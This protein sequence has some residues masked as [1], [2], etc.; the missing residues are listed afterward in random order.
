MRGC[1]GSCARSTMGDA[2]GAAC[3]GNGGLTDLNPE[4][5]QLAVNPRRTPERVGKAHLADQFACFPV[6]GLSPR[7]R[8]PA[9]VE[10]KALAVPL[11]HGCRLHQYHGP[12]ATRPDPVEPDPQHPI[13]GVQAQT[14][15]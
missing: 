7:A 13:D 1:A 9:P 8:S 15:A 11:D 3:V 4:L 12:E 5:E 2:A 14:A 10:L 6:N